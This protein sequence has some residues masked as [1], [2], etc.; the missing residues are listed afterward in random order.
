MARSQ[1]S[2]ATNSARNCFENK[3]FD[4]FVK[5]FYFK[6]QYCANIL[7]SLQQPLFWRV[8]LNTP[9]KDKV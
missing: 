8:G 9:S 5:D 7:H 4:S 1:V 6:E 3:F 2:R